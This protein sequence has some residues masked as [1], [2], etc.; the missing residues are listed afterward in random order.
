MMLRWVRQAGQARPVQSIRRDFWREGA[1]LCKSAARCSL[2][3]RKG[4]LCPKGTSVPRGPVPWPPVD[5]PQRAQAIR[6]ITTRTHC[7]FGAADVHIKNGSSHGTAARTSHSQT[8]PQARSPA[9]QPAYQLTRTRQPVASQPPAAPASIDPR[10][11]HP[12]VQRPTF[13][14]D[15]PSPAPSQSPPA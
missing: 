4:N 7:Q 2:S 14:S 5:R 8:G 1:F 6:S 13:A 11:Y 3:Q 12:S 15:T 10:R 9:H